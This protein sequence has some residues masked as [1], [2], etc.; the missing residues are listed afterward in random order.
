VLPATDAVAR[1]KA[2][3]QEENPKSRPLSSEE[4]R[5]ALPVIKAARILEPSPRI[6]DPAMKMRTLGRDGVW[7]SWLVLL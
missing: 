3:K 1:E 5:R 7:E 2:E 4:R 6:T